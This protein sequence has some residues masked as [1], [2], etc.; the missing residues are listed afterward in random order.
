MKRK[1]IIALAATAALGAAT[2]TDT[3]A[4]A[5][6]GGAGGGH[7]GA[8][9]SGGSIGGRAGAFGGAGANI[10]ARPSAGVN[11][12]SMNTNAGP[13][14]A[15]TAMTRN[16]AYNGNWHGRG[17]R[18]GYGWGGWGFTGLYAHAGPDYGY[19]GYPYYYDYNYGYC[20]PYDYA[21]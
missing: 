19:C 10:A 13:V 6:H 14:G 2:M 8:A 5:F 12:L 7:V 11:N 17:H 15:R 18:Y 21:W 3:S 1:T 9:V 20:A 4:F 16:Y